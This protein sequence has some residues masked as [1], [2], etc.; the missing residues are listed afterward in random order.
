MLARKYHYK[1]ADDNNNRMGDNILH[2]SN[3]KLY[4]ARWLAVT[5]C[6]STFRSF[7]LNLG[8]STSSWLRL[9]SCLSVLRR[10]SMS[11]LMRINLMRLVSTLLSISR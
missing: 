11:F 8:T 10:C 3:T 1:S 4:I 7:R 5:Q 6:I 2:I 9:R